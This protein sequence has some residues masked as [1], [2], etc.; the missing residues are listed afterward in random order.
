MHLS[1]ETKA[2]YDSIV[3]WEERLEALG[4]LANTIEN[5]H[6]INSQHMKDTL[7]Q[8]LNEMDLW[9]RSYRNEVEDEFQKIIDEKSGYEQREKQRANEKLKEIKNL[10]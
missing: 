9:Y 8:F 1:E 10:T 6:L 3:M 4:L 2:Y 5:G 7:E